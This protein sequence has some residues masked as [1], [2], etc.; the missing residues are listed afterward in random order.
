MSDNV[1]VKAFIWAKRS[2]TSRL[3]V[4]RQAKKRFRCVDMA[5]FLGVDFLRP[6]IVEVG[7]PTRSFA[8]TSFRLQHN[9]PLRDDFKS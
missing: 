1:S 2:V 8:H 3:Q 4:M 5:L 9:G 6:S 7:A